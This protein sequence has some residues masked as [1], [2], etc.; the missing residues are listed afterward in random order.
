MANDESVIFL[1]YDENDPVGFAQAYPSFT[2]IGMKRIWVLNDLFVQEK[3]RKKGFG[4]K[5]LKK[6]IA[7]AEETDAKGVLLETGQ[8]NIHAQRLYEKTGFEKES[9]FY[10]F[11]TI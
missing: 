11:F 5:L 8:D 1:A 2:S 7:F 10:Y 4:E 9:N 6:V 3:A